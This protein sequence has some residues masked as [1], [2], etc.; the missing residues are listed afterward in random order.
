MMPVYIVFIVFSFIALMVKWENDLVFSIGEKM[1]A[2]VHLE[3]SET[4]LSFKCSAQ[5][6]ADLVERPGCRPA[7]YLARASWVALEHPDALESEELER[8]L[9]SAYEIVLEAHRALGHPEQALQH[10]RAQSWD[11]AEL[12]FF[13]LKRAS[14]GR[15]LYQVYLD[16]IEFYRSEPPGSDWDGVFTHTSK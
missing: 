11:K 10:F 4:W 1:F 2:A 8:L 15:L 6:F 9:K 14:P 12:D 5:D 16:R 13:D 7:P 3:P